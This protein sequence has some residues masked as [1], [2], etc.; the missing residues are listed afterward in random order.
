M[1]KILLTELHSC[2]YLADKQAR[3]GFVD[4][5]VSVNQ[6]LYQTLNNLGFRRSGP[7]FY[8]PECPG[9]NACQ[10]VRI[11]IHQ[12][13]PNR[14]QRRIYQRNDDLDIKLV[15]AE[16]RPD[17][18]RLYENY[19]RTRHEDGDMFPPSPEQFRGFLIEGGIR[20]FHLEIH[21][22]GQ[23][24]GCAVTDQL[25]DGL[26]AIYTFFDPQLEQRSLGTFAIM[27]QV[28]LC[29]EWQLPY[30]YLGYWVPGSQKMMYKTRFKPLEVLRHGQW[31]A[32][33]DT[34]IEFQ[35]TNLR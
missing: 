12:F 3:T 15:K 30:L 34:D 20:T 11:P 1:M 5:E 35:N 6:E 9:C 2:S 16:F 13:K 10:S 32:L 31:T 23:L 21:H 25:Q 24:I 26:S 33:T 8:R 4:P 27:A 29:R 19:I 28:Q 14:N 18:Y 7:H 17:N 22:Q